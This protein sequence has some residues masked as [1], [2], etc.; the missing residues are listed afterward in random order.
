[1][2]ENIKKLIE[3]FKTSYICVSSEGVLSDDEE[4]IYFA[5]IGITNTLNLLAN[6]YKKTQDKQI[7]GVLKD[8]DFS[9]GY[10]LDSL[11]E[12]EVSHDV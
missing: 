10:I 7:L 4:R 5:K 9:I 2:D 3:Q 8:V 11:Y 6:I 1:M 12:K